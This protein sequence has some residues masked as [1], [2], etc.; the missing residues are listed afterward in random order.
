MI[1]SFLTEEFVEGN[2]PPHIQVKDEKGNI[3]ETDDSDLELSSP[4]VDPEKSAALAKVIT[5]SE[6][7]GT[8]YA[9]SIDDSLMPPTPMTISSTSE[10]EDTLDIAPEHYGVESP[11]QNSE[12]EDYDFLPDEDL[13]RKET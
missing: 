8:D 9:P 13:A 2:R 6:D 1:H 12:S 3:C 4:C 11:S 7:E 10:V 5:D